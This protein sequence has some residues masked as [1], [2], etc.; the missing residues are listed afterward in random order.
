MKERIADSRMIVLE[1]CGHWT[2]FEKPRECM[3]EL[4]SFYQSIN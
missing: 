3:R 4:K 1:G 2:T